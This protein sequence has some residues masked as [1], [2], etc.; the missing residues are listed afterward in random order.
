MSNGHKVN[1]SRNYERYGTGAIFTGKQINALLALSTPVLQAIILL[2]IM[3]TAEPAT[4]P[5]SKYGP[6]EPAAPGD[7]AGGN[8]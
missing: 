4:D 7:D 2:Q 8:G 6:V 1:E 5:K 3:P